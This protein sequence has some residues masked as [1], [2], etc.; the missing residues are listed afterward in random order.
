[1]PP[2]ESIPG[3]W[4][5]RLNSLGV[6]EPEDPSRPWKLEIA[7]LPAGFVGFTFLCLY[8]LVEELVL[9]ALSR[10]ALIQ[11]VIESECLSDPLLSKIEITGP[12]GS[13]EEV[14]Y[15]SLRS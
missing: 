1:M 2:H 3:L 12:D 14:T 5:I 7:L 11:F 10:E 9:Q 4:L 6:N 15:E 8:G 13:T